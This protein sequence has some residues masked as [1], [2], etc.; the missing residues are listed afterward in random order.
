M[1]KK[2][3][4][5]SLYPAAMKTQWDLYVKNKSTKKEKEKKK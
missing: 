3:N 2:N 5:N 4:Y 1:K